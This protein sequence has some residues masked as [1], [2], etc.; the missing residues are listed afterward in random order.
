MS[1]S[2]VPALIDALIAAATAVLPDVTV[3][4]CWPAELNSG[5]WLLFG[6]ADPDVNRTVGATSSQSYPHVTRPARA[7]TGEVF[8]VVFCAHGDDDA[9]GA[10]DAAYAVLGAVETLLRDSVTLNVPGVWKTN[11]SPGDYTPARF[12]DY[13]G[14]AVTVQFKVEFEARI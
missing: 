2:V 1:T 7:E 11:L 6:V 9:K 14:A 13:G 8:G 10:R 3:S 5:D 12:A 4:D